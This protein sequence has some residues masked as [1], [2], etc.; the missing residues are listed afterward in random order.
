M[1][2]NYQYLGHKTLILFIIEKS[3]VFF[4]FLFITII[5][6]ILNIFAAKPIS[7]FVSKNLSFLFKTELNFSPTLKWISII[8]FFISLI[9]LGL[10]ILI[11]WLKYVNYR[12]V[13]DDNALKIKRGIL[14]KEEVSI[15]Y[16]RIQDVNVDRV[17]FYRT[18]G[19][20]RLVVLTASHEEQEQGEPKSEA[21]GILPAIDHDLAAKIKEDLLRRS[22]VERVVID[23][24]Q[25]Y[26]NIDK[27][28]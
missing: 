6:F 2:I 23:K 9:A 18:I 15:P 5:S 26:K 25:Q 12:F 3:K 20:S 13:L 19:L 11:G 7:F 4:L 22:S 1:E 10:A 27:K 28:N 17:L 24:N 21:E 8:G 14:N 16:Q